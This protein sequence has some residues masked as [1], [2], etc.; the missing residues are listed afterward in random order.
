MFQQLVRKMWWEIFLQRFE[1]YTTL[2]LLV[3]TQAIHKPVWKWCRPGLGHM[4]HNTED[5]KQT[6]IPADIQTL[7]LWPWREQWKL[8]AWDS[9]SVSSSADI[10]ADIQTLWLWPWREPW[11]LLAWVSASVSSSADTGWRNAHFAVKKLPW[12]WPQPWRQHSKNIF[13]QLGLDDAPA[14]KCAK[15][16]KDIKWSFYEALTL[17]CDLDFEDLY[18]SKCFAYHSL[19][20][21]VTSDVNHTQNHWSAEH[22]HTH[23]H[24]KKTTTTNIVIIQI[25]MATKCWR[26][27]VGLM[28]NMMLQK[29]T[30]I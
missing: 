15:W 13:A 19:S 5:M 3:A 14:Y 26:R 4:F 29:T 12:F 7:W 1:S 8:L 9:A 17:Y 2:S 30:R 20:W 11:K 6:D 10:P 24:T 18:H 27:K 22:A 23:T 25:I 28:T 21:R 16:F